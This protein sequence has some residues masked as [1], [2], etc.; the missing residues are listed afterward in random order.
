MKMIDKVRAP[1]K[2]MDDTNRG[3]CADYILKLSKLS[4][5]YSSM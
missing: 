3:H 5:M 4:E 1:I 2:T